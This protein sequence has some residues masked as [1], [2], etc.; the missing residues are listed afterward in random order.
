MATGEKAVFAEIME[1]REHVSFISG[2]HVP[3]IAHNFCHVL[4]KSQSKYPKFKLYKKNIVFLT[5]DEHFALDHGR[6]W[7]RN[8]YTYTMMQK[9]VHVNWQ[10][11]YDLREELLTEY[12]EL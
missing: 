11:L 6:E 9:G 4:S 10:K 12:K 2:L 7:D 5:Q 1:E 8:Q 3:C